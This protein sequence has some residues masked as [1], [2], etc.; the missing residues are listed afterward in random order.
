M[1]PCRSNVFLAFLVVLLVAVSADRVAEKDEHAAAEHKKVHRHRNVLKISEEDKTV[2]NSL[3]ELDGIDH[4]NDR[5][6]K[7]YA[8]GASSKGSSSSSEKGMMKGSKK[9]M[10]MKGSK[11]GMMMKGSKKG[12]MMKGSKK[13]MMSSKSS[14]G[15]GMMKS[16]NEGMS[17]YYF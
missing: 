6:L 4:N 17:F 11:K 13:G 14:K 8:T 12:M 2:L 3:W 15:M 16:S 7:V 9:G 1:S 10:M 5:G